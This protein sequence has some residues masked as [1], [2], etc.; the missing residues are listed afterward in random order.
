MWISALEQGDSSNTWHVLPDRDY[1]LH[2]IDSEDCVCGPKI[3]AVPR[4]DGSF[5]WLIVHHS[6]DGRENYE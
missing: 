5:G 2:D 4:T 1:I 3:E 6:L